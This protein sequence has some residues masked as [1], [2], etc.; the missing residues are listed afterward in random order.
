MCRIGTE[1]EDILIIDEPAL[2]LHPIK[3][4]H[5]GRTLSSYAKRQIILVTHST[6]FVNLS[7][8]EEKRCLISIQKGLDGISKILNKLNLKLDL[9]P[10]NFKP[11]IFFS[12]CDIFVEGASDAAAL[13]AISD[14]LD[15][16]LE[17]R[18][19]FIVDSGGRDVVEKYI[20]IIDTYRLKHVAMVDND[21]QDEDRKKTNDF[22]L[23][24]GKL[25]DELRNLG[26]GSNA[27]TYGTDKNKC[28]CNTEKSKSISASAAYN[29]ISDKMRNEKDSVMATKL[30]QVFNLALENVG[31][32]GL[33]GS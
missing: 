8:F 30:G 2:R 1:Q 14:S 11:E 12:K 5:L 7:L 23:L 18:D 19:I 16:I 6:Y 28:K 4:K 17:K 29:F 20:E 10:Y 3:I 15:H 22:V 21:Y 32:T 25:E 24:P 31:V 27:D 33:T 9:K 13:L 26:W